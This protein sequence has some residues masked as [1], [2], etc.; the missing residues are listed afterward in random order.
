M[1]IEDEGRKLLLMLEWPPSV[2]HYWRASGNRRY[3]SPR[4]M[5][6]RQHVIS[7]MPTNWLA[8]KGRLQVRIDAYPPDYRRRDLD[9]ILKAILDSLEHAKAYLDDNQ[10]DKIMVI[11]RDV[12]SGEGKVIITVETLCAL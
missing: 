3:I 1:E 6:F 2:N 8:F 9:N 12:I 11:R 4:G 10:I 7:T 5:A